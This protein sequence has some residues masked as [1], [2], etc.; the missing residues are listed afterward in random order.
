MIL[1]LRLLQIYIQ[2]PRKDVFE[3]SHV[4]F[5]QFLPT[6]TFLQIH[7]IHYHNQGITIDTVKI[8]NCLH[9]DYSPAL[10]KSHP[11]SNHNDLIEQW[12]RLQK[13]CAENLGEIPRG[14]G[15]LSSTPSILS[16][17]PGGYLMCLPLLFQ[18]CYVNIIICYVTFRI[19]LFHSTRFP[20]DHPSCTY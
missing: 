7:S 11:P 16:V 6:V 2:P 10:L 5:P 12:L 17:I 4:D 9:K 1:T 14:E 18:E 8:Q 19:G 20:G 15:G 3:R 13:L